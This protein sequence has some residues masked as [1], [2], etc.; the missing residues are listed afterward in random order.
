M[1]D[2]KPVLEIGSGGG[3]FKEFFPDIISS[4]FIC[5]EWI[6]LNIDAHIM[7]FKQG[8]LGNIVFIDVLHHLSN[9]ILFFNEAQR[10]LQDKG[11]LIMLEPYI[12]PFSYVI[13]K[14]FHQEDMDFDVDVWSKQIPDN[15]KKAFD[16]NSAIPT[17]MFSKKNWKFHKEFPNLKV[18]KKE[19]LA[20]ILY[21][22]SGGFDRKSY[23]PADF[24][25]YLGFV[26]KLLQ[27]F[28]FIFALRTLVVIEKCV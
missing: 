8:S 22:L 28:N 4:D 15:K 21:P 12:S 26:E 1:V 2:N 18:V 5:C 11:R 9:P 10:V 7:P 24:I 25:K 13:Y 27:P 6:D 20:F 16:G 14:Y 17:M 23:V 19:R 3:N